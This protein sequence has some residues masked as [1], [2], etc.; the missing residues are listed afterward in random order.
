[1]VRQTPFALRCTPNTSIM[2]AQYLWIFGSFVIFFLG[3]LHLYY[4]FF[5]DKFS[6]RNEKM[7]GEMKISFPNLTKETTMWKAW[8]GFNASHSSGAMFIGLMNIY[9]AL[10]Y[11]PILVNDHFFFL[12]SILTLVFYAWLGKIYWF[13]IPLIGILTTLGCYIAGYI[14]S[15]TSP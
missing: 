6:S 8:I 12:F 7:I 15:F 13:K 3:S 2:L 10:Y 11:F 9:L 1:M 14:L 4:T 5:S